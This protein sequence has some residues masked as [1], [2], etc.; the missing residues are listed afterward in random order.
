[1]KYGL[2]RQFAGQFENG[3]PVNGKFTYEN[4]DTYEGTIKNNKP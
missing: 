3:M 2:N 1:M 4:G